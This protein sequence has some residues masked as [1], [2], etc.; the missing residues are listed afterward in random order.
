M[1]KSDTNTDAANGAEKVKRARAPSKPKPV[2]VVL[3]ILDENGNP[4]SVSKDRVNVIG[5]TKS[6]DGVLAI[7]ESGTA[8]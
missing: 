7:T 3:Q 6:S 8:L 2:Y 1:A 4:I 5:F